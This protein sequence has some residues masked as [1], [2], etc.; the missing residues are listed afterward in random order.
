MDFEQ[1]FSI[2]SAGQGFCYSGWLKFQKAEAFRFVF[3]CGSNNKSAL[4]REIKELRLRGLTD[5][6]QL[7]LLVISHFDADHVNMIQELLEGGI[8]VKK[9]V[10]P[11]LMFHERLFLVL[12]Q[13]LGRKRISDAEIDSFRIML[14]PLG[15]LRDNL[16]GEGGIFLISGD[17]QPI[18]GGQST[19]GEIAE[20]ESQKAYLRDDF[21]SFNDRPSQGFS[22]DFSRSADT[23]EAAQ[24]FLQTTDAQLKVVSDSQKAFVSVGNERL[25]EF[26]FYKKDIGIHE[27]EFFATVEQLFYEKEGITPHDPDL[28]NKVVDTLKAG[29]RSAGPVRRLFNEAA[30]KVGVPPSTVIDLNNTALCMLHRNT[31]GLLARIITTNEQSYRNFKAETFTYHHFKSHTQMLP[32]WPIY[33]MLGLG[34]P[35]VLLTS[36]SFLKS[37]GEIH[38]FKNKYRHYLDDFWLIQIPHHGSAKSSDNDFFGIVPPECTYFVNYGL[39][40]RHGHPSLSVMQKVLPPNWI[41]PYLIHEYQGF[42]FHYGINHEPLY[43]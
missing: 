3:D 1:Q 11:F 40:N 37:S 43:T 13:F 2:H 20:E 39:N 27:E 17:D 30:R 28:I 15:T 23:I 22:F 41:G 33:H 32:V 38:A 18:P 8:I 35:N 26:L 16:G 5:R 12:K 21:A 31:P 10:M 7:D 34:Y 6:G 42:Q 36:D 14:D 24:F 4:S 25:M 29:Y 9:L 19:T